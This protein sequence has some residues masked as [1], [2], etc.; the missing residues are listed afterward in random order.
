MPRKPRADAKLRSLPP[1]RKDTLRQWLVDENISYEE[2]VKRMGELWNL[3]SSVGAVSDFFAKECFSLR[4]R[5]ASK[6]AEDLS[7]TLKESPQVFDEA[8][9]KA[10]SQ[11][12]FELAVAKDANVG[13]LV[14]LAKIIG[15]TARLKLKA[16]EV[17]LD[18]RRISI[19]EKREAQA[20]A[21]ETVARNPALTPQ[22]REQKIKE[23]FGIQ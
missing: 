17:E 22:E 18:L 4:F 19:L 6:L 13:E 21:A 5:E 11:K 3:K 10:I 2:V 16:Q 9:N 1:E 20:E 23:V 14:Q 8:T 12:A 7:A 15:D